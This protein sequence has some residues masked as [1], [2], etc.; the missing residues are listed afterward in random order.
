M[1]GVRQRNI[2]LRTQSY[3]QLKTNWRAR[4]VQISI[5]H[6]AAEDLK[7]IVTMFI[8][9]GLPVIINLL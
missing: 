9:S 5:K 7:M 4:S 8:S 2:E 6:E 3:D 1:S